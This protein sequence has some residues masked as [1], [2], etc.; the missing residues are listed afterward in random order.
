MDTDSV[1]YIE[2]CLTMDTDS[3]RYIERCLTMD[4]DIERC[5]TM[6]HVNA[7][8]ADYSSKS[9]DCML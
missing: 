3:A 6:G 4:T 1:R 7:E 8:S 5:I 2:Q 9:G